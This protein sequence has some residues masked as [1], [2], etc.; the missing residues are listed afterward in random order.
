M[1][2]TPVGCRE[3]SDCRDNE[4]CDRLSQNCL[5][6][7]SPGPCAEGARC[8]A[9]GHREVCTC[10]PPL[11]GDGYA[12][13]TSPIEA[14]P[15]PECRVDRDCPVK[16]ACIEDRCQN[17]CLTSNP[18]GRNQVCTVEDSYDGRR[19]VGCTCPPGQV[20]AGSNSCKTGRIEIKIMK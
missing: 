12:F 20:A 14:D 8:E 13:C 1:S 15:E 10:R 4:R 19:T 2:C 9:R 7:C 17:P 16:M 5:P 18:C 11:Q 3:H 6:L